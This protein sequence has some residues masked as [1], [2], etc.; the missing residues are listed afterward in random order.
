MK[1]KALRI[2]LFALAIFL[3]LIAVYKF[4]LSGHS[5][6]LFGQN[7][8]VEYVTV[9]LGSVQQDILIRGENVDNPILL[10]IHGGPGD[11]ETSFIVPYQ[12]EWEKYYTVVNWDQRGSGRSYHSDIDI[13]TLNTEQIC[14]DAKQLTDYLK[15]RFGKEKIFL[16]GH[17]YGTYVAALCVRNNPDD[18]YAYVGTGQIGDQQENELKLIEYAVIMSENDGNE[19]AL[20]ELNSLPQMPYT[21]ENFGKAI[22]ASRKWT[23]YYGGAIYGQKDTNA[24]YAR[25]LI[26]MEYSFFD[27]MSFL[28]GEELYYTN[29]ASDIA[30]WELF[31]AN[32]FEEAPVLEVPVFF[33]QGKND[34]ITS[35]SMC[36]KY[37]NALAAPEKYLYPIDN[38]SHDVICEKTDEF[39]NILINDV[40]KYSEE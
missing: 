23:T 25:A 34:Y 14:S 4:V 19:D 11:P 21:T 5:T 2:T 31:N 17:S 15:E 18:Y 24:L 38:C 28:K 16:V 3:L 36:E 9:E 35:Y 1:K 7:S 20:R 26:N 13:S 8:I 30:R 6:P 33:V 27:L 12:R 32:L 40:R 22:A 39:T 29:T 10:Y 37:Y